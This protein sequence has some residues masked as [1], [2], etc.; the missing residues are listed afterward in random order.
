MEVV[1]PKSSTLN[2][3]TPALQ[4]RRLPLELGN[5]QNQAG[6]LRMNKIL[7]CFEARGAR[8]PSDGVP[9]SATEEEAVARHGIY[10]WCL[11]RRLSQKASSGREVTASPHVSGSTGRSFLCLNRGTLGKQFLLLI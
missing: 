9:G 1:L 8:I 11:H 2:A 4:N 10:Q 3:A 7:R 5:V 6:I